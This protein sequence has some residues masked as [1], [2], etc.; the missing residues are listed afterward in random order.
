MDIRTVV[1]M[2]AVAAVVVAESDELA[3]LPPQLTSSRFDLDAW[4]SI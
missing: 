3:A 4:G 1:R 2:A